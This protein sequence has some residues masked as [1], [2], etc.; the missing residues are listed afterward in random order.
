MGSGARRAEGVGEMSVREVLGRGGHASRLAETGRDCDHERAGYLVRMRR[1]VYVSSSAVQWAEA[2][3]A[4]GPRSPRFRGTGDGRSL[5]VA[6]PEGT[7][8]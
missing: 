7:P 3:Q 6:I 1:G 5:G 2:D 8:R 4:R